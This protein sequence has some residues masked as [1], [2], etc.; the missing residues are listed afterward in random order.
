MR[1]ARGGKDSIDHAPG[2]HHDVANAACG[3]LSL[4]AARRGY[5]SSMSWVDGGDTAGLDR[6]LHAMRG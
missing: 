3:A 2:G 5:D 6:Y 1:F 4:V